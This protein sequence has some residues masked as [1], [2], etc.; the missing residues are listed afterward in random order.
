MFRTS[1]D[2]FST[3]AAHAA[4]EIVRPV[5]RRRPGAR[6]PAAVG[7]RPGTLAMS[8]RD[9]AAADGREGEA[10]QGCAARDP[11]PPT[12]RL[13]LRCGSHAAGSIHRVGRVLPGFYVL[14]DGTQVPGAQAEVVDA[15]GARRYGRRHYLAAA[16]FFALLIYAGFNWGAVWVPG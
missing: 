4:L 8:D 1:L 14:A 9:R 6:V 15:G 12:I 13:K 11:E 16:A 5:G 3:M 7:D 10:P 2:P